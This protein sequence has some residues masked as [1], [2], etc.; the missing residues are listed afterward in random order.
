MLDE[1]PLPAAQPRIDT[2][3]AGEETLKPF[4]LFCPWNKKAADFV[5]LQ[6]SCPDQRRKQIRV[7]CAS[8]KIRLSVRRQLLKRR[9]KTD[10]VPQRSGKDNQDLF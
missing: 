2:G 10:K 8:K 6:G 7:F 5:T 3:V 1:I 9:G 4:V